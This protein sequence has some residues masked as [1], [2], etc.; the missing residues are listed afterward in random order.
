MCV[1]YNQEEVKAY[2]VKR[3]KISRT[4]RWFY[5]I[6]AEFG[7]DVFIRLR[8]EKD[9]W[10]NLH[11]LI[12]IES[13]TPLTPDELYQNA[14]FKTLGELKTL[15]ISRQ[16]QQHLTHQTIKGQFIHVR[17]FER[18]DLPGYSN[19]KRKDI[20]KLAF[21]KFITAYFNESRLLK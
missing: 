5:Y 3:K 4:I 10:Q 15:D 6:V 14:C 12:L 11:D 18:P 20:Q 2:P 16:Y 1:A 19:E 7:D 21:P 17:L 8:T 9:I 13:K